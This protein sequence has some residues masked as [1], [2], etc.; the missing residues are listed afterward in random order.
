[1]ETPEYLDEIRAELQGLESK[2]ERLERLVE[3]GKELEK[4]PEKFMVAENKVPGC[5]STVYIK[6]KLDENGKLH[7]KGYS[8]SFIVA[9]YVQILATALDSM[10]PKEVVAD[11][12]KLKESD[13]EAFDAIV[14]EYKK[15]FEDGLK[16]LKE[17]DLE[18]LGDAMNRN[19]ALLR[20][21]TVSSRLMD[22]LQETALQNGAI[23]AKLTGTGRGGLL[24]ALTP[25]RKI[26]GKVAKAFEK[27]GFQVTRTQIGI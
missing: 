7:F 25:D 6:E 26:Q 12:R 21:I 16:A 14:K 17:Y 5:M 15:V 23:G 20:K 11:V 19:Q 18:K 2:M 1:M 8:N 3:I 22:E 4:F 10:K 13:G 27:K 9:G 24:I